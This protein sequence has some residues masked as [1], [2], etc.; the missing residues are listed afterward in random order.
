MVFSGDTLSSHAEF[1][2]S[3]NLPR[4][5]HKFQTTIS[6]T[7]WTFIDPDFSGLFLPYVPV[8]PATKMTFLPMKIKANGS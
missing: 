5:L 8:L 2:Q 4:G 7:F 6:D 1:R 3:L